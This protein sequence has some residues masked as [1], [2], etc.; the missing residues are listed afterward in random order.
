MYKNYSKKQFEYFLRGLLIENKLGFL[1]EV[2]NEHGQTW[3]HIYEVTTRNRAVTIIIFSSVDMRTGRTRENGADRVRLVLRWKTKN[4]Y[5][6]KRIAR[7]N[8]LDTLFNNIKST[9]LNF[10]PFGQFDFKEFSSKLP[11]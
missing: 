9:L 1:S 6:Y 3:E 5:V 8:R 10:N 11:F 7:H 4:G 2:T